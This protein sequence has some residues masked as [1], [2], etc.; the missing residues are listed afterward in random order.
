MY[1]KEKEKEKRKKT[2]VIKKEREIENHIL[3]NICPS[4]MYYAL[5]IIT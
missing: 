2:S 1:K 4:F 3:F 5:F